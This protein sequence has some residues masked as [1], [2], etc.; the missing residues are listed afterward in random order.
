MKFKKMM[1]GLASGMV[2]GLALSAGAQAAGYP[3]KPITAI[4]PFPAGGSTDQ[5]ARAIGPRITQKLGQ[6]WIV[7]NKPGATGAIGAAQ[8]KRSPP[9]GYTLLVASIGVYSVNPVLQKNLQYDPAKDFDLLT[10]A[11]RAP[12]VLVASPSFPANNVADLVTNLKKN[13]GKITFANSGAGSSDHLTAALFWQKT[14]T[15]GVH[16]PYKGGAPAITDLLGGHADV[17]FQNINA[18]VNHIKTGKL[19]AL[20]ITGDKRSPL[21]PN[22]P[23]LAE[24]GVKEADV[25]SWQGIAAPK[26]LQPDVKT[27]LHDAIVGALNDPEVKRGLVEQGFEVVANTPEQFTKFQAQELAR[28][29]QVITVGKIEVD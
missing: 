6:S 25:Y 16:V 1:A 12:N 21:L 5:I 10:V 28:W 18:V 8:V 2:F 24:A 14:G 27:K 4:V 13:P 11:V 19:K 23:T 7:E 22:V 9:D 29:K 17:S 20:A 3:E 26:G 15:T